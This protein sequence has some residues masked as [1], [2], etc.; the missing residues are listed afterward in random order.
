MFL[1]HPGVRI[2]FTWTVV[3]SAAYVVSR[4]GVRVYPR[5]QVYTDRG[6]YRWYSLGATTS[7]G[8]GEQAVSRCDV[9]WTA[10]Y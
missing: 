6:G 5:Y 3:R 9:P 4:Y 7:Y 8:Y 2:E 1:I 10:G